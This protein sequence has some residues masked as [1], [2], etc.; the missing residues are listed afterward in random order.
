MDAMKK[1]DKAV[2]LECK[3]RGMLLEICNISAQW[4]KTGDEVFSGSTFTIPLGD[5][6]IS[7]KLTFNKDDIEVA[8]TS[9]VQ[10]TIHWDVIYNYEYRFSDGYGTLTKNGKKDGPA[11]DKC[12]KEAV[13]ALMGMYYAWKSGELKR[14]IPNRVLTESYFDETRKTS[15]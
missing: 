5:E 12:K 10:M 3:Q 15:D 8:M 13:R 14:F 7:G 4:E 6:T 1:V 2:I 11:T 9:P